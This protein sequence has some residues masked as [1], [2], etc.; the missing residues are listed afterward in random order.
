MKRLLILLLVFIFL[1]TAL[2][3][4]KPVQKTIKPL[5]DAELPRGTGTIAIVDVNLIDVNG[6]KAI[7]NA[8]VI[9]KGNKIIAAGPSGSIQIPQGAEII[10]GKGMSLLP[11]L[12][13]S[14]FHIDGSDELPSMFLQNGIT[15]LRDPG[16]WIEMYDQVRKSGKSNPR[17]FLSGPHLDG[18]PPAYPNDAYV[19]R[20]DAE[21]VRQVNEVADQG[22]T[23]IKIYFRT[24]PGM[25]KAITDAA[26]KRGIPVTGHLEIT[27]AKHAI[28]AGLDGIEHITSFGLSLT[29]KREAEK[30]R[31]AMLAD[32]NY[33]KQ[34]RYKSWA[35]IDLNSPAA[36]SLTRFLV[37]KG[38]FVSP[39]LAIFEY[40]PSPGT[41]DSIKLKGFDQMMK[42]TAKL[43][44]GGAK[45]VV[46]SH[47]MVPYAE[48]GWAYQREMELFVES[49][50]SNAAVIHAATMENARFFR[51]ENQ[52]GSIEKGKLADLI[53]VRGNP[54][55]D[56][57]VMRNIEKV[58]INGV[59]VR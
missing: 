50:M 59:F 25:I 38:T 19:V 7:Q 18:S 56:I 4:Q 57:K 26:H 21:A 17:L 5:N 15:S 34:G 51:I 13:D 22:S 52:L 53:L 47:G 46:G 55:E 27:E 29:P 37:R 6:G 49:G 2:F 39:T 33:R 42:L 16:L 31:Q 10:Q 28:E 36:D 58:M 24:P 23:V 11:G 35:E 48:K 20:D 3:A 30:Y 43:Q 44:K 12:I 45:V 14:H 40:Q 8:S 9:V 1:A 32:N 41:I 54:L